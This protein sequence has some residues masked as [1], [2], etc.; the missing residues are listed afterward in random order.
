MQI[1]FMRINLNV[2]LIYS[3]HWRLILRILDSY[4]RQFKLNA[5]VAGTLPAN[6]AQWIFI[7]G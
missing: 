7:L 6:K 3:A 2:Q 1:S 4:L 5:F